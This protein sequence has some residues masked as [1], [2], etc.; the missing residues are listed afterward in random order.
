MKLNNK[1]IVKH[2]ITFKGKNTS[3]CCS[4]NLLDNID[5]TYLMDNYLAASWCWLKKID[6]NNKYNLFHIDQHYDLSEDTLPFLENKLIESKIRFID[7]SIE[8]LLCLSF[9]HP[10]LSLENEIQILRWNN[11]LPIFKKL[12]PDIINKT[13]F[14]THQE[15]GAD[16]KYIDY[17]LS[18]ID[19]KNELAYKIRE[20]SCNKWIVNLDIDYFFTTDHDEKIYQCFSDEYILQIANEINESWD[21]IE[22]FTIA[23]SPECCGGWEKSLRIAKIITECIGVDWSFE[24]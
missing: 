3:S 19:L 4:L 13:F 11:Y 14:A 17:E 2:I 15:D 5:K 21:S 23:L 12:Y 6:L 20:M 1:D 10:S 22:V 18:F 7:A 24:K 9:Q 16:K 8:E